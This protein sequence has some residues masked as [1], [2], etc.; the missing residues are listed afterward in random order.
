MNHNCMTSQQRGMKNTTGNESQLYDVTAEQ[1]SRIQVNC[2][3]VSTY[4]VQVNLSLMPAIDSC[5][6]VARS[7][8]VNFECSL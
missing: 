6:G 8:Y 2:D 3:T 5:V 4:T 7:C 1:L